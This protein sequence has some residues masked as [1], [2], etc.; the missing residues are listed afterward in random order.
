[1]SQLQ[2]L[3][4]DDKKLLERP[5][6]DLQTDEELFRKYELGFNQLRAEVMIEAKKEWHRRHPRQKFHAAYAER[7]RKYWNIT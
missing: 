3:S 4:D 1:M 5:A 2:E 7:V 6:K